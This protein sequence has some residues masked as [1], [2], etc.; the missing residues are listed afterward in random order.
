MPRLTDHG[1]FIHAD[2]LVLFLLVE[3]A[4]FLDD[5][6]G[7]APAARAAGLEVHVDGTV[8]E[9]DADEVRQRFGVVERVLPDLRQHGLLNFG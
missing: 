4:Q 8:G 6:V 3:V 1:G 7:R 5:F 9:L 2:G